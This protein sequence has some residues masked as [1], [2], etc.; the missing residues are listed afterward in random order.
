MNERNVCV[1]RNARIFG[2][3]AA[4]ALWGLLAGIK[5]EIYY[6][7]ETYQAKRFVPDVFVDISS[8]YDKVW[9]SLRLYQ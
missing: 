1:M 8:V 6:F 2:P 5:P 9:E 3:L 4:V 7:E